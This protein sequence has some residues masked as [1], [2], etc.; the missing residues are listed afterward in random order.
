MN[1]RTTSSPPTTTVIPEKARIQTGRATGPTPRPSHSPII[2]PGRANLPFARIPFHSAPSRQRSRRDPT[3]P[4]SIAPNAQCEPAPTSAPESGRQGKQIPRVENVNRH[5]SIGIP[6]PIA[7]GKLEPTFMK[8]DNDGSTKVRLQMKTRKTIRSSGWKV[9]RTVG[10]TAG[11]FP[12]RVSRQPLPTNRI[13]QFTI[14]R[15]HPAN[16]PKRSTVW[17]HTQLSTKTQGYDVSTCR[18]GVS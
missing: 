8:V 16:S 4:L 5:L 18:R 12:R 11:A 3:N 1:G 6:S 14:K 7:F 15:S 17:D 2:H 9:A 13:T 10:L